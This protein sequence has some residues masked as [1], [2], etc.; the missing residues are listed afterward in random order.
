MDRRSVWIDN[1]D[2]KR[3]SRLSIDTQLN[4]SLKS[5]HI[6]QI[7]LAKLWTIL[8]FQKLCI[9]SSDLIRHHGTYVTK[10]SFTQINLSSQT[11]LFELIN[12]LMSNR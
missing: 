6:D 4:D 7:L 3:S 9:W 2:T 1:I 11:T 12:I 5:V 10:D 8:L